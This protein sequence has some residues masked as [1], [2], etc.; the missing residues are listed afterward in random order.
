[1]RILYIN[2]DSLWVGWDA[3]ILLCC[4]PFDG[5]NSTYCSLAAQAARA[6]MIVSD[7][8]TITDGGLD[9][10]CS[11]FVTT[12]KTDN[13]GT[14]SDTSITIPTFGSGY[15]YD[16]DWDNDGIFDEFGIMG[17]VTHDLV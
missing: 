1:M 17:N 8:W 6:N 4:V 3:K 15:N 13:P 2:Y 12:W 10:L 7:S 5:G 11:H 9:S 14:S 16:V